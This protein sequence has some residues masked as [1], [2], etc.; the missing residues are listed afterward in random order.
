MQAACHKE[1]AMKFGAF[2]LLQSPEM[3]PGS[4]VYRDTLDYAELADRLG[5]DHIWVAEHHFS[6]YGYVPQPLM[7]A[8]ALAG[9]VR[10][11][12]IGTGVL[13]LPL[14]DP[15]RLAEEIAMADVLTGGR[16][17]I[18]IGR[19]YQPYEF[20]RFGLGLDDSR[21]RYEE[22]LEIL[23][24]ALSQTNFASEGRYFQIPPTTVLPRPL[25][26]PHP[27]IWTVAVSPATVEFTVQRGYNCLVNAPL[28]ALRD[29]RSVWN[30]ASEK[31]GGT[32]AELGLHRHTY[33][34]ESDADANA[35]L[36]H[37]YWHYRASRHLRAGTQVVVDG[38][39]IDQP[40]ADEPGPDEM[41]AKNV[42]FGTPDQIIERIR[43]YEREVGISYAS[44]FFALGS[45]DRDRVVRSM[46]TFAAKVMP[47][48]R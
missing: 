6:T 36:H 32:S 37:A 29:L 12:R 47:A 46:E 13:V 43:T 33:V 18:G 10:R 4:E 44:C 20:E 30:A 39:A 11:A 22:S 31:A 14:H 38:Q 45:M 1:A 17:D 2:F 16:L 41:R 34:A 42:L 23:L 19:G 5:F 28:P 24:S 40:F 7:F 35:E 26:R 9:R 27:P 48:F 21:E 8:V 3:R 25:Q 15:V